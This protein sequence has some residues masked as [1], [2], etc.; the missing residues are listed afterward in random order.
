MNSTY[1]AL[2]APLKARP[3]SGRRSRRRHAGSRR[4]ACRKGPHP[5]TRPGCSMS[6]VAGR[7]HSSHATYTSAVCRRRFSCSSCSWC[8]WVAAQCFCCSWSHRLCRSVMSGSRRCRSSRSLAAAWTCRTVAIASVCFGQRPHAP[9]APCC[10]SAWAWTLSVHA[11]FLTCA[12]RL[13]R[14][15]CSCANRRRASSSSRARAWVWATEKRVPGHQGLFRG[16]AWSPPSHPPVRLQIPRP[17]FG[18]ELNCTQTCS[19]PR[20]RCSFSRRRRA[21]FDSTSPWYMARSSAT[22]V[23][24]RRTA[25]SSPPPWARPVSTLGAHADPPRTPEDCMS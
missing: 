19:P 9:H 4:R 8:S 22:C 2:R 25:L 17:A 21:P 15:A 18:R 3:G 13:S 7:K 23:C 24:M 1:S 11:A 20:L 14:S 6:D 10:V 12:C 16:P 5:L